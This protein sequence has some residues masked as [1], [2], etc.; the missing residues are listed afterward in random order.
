MVLPLL[1]SCTVLA[2]FE[3]IE[4]RINGT[5]FQLESSFYYNGSSGCALFEEGAES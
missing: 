1:P 4:L 2:T 5:G 3:F